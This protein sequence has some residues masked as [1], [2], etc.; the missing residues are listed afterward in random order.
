MKKLKVVLSSIV[1]VILAPILFVS[2][3][4]LINSYTNPDEVPSFFGWKPFIVLSGSMETEIYSGDVAVVKEVDL[5]EIN[6]NDIIA[7][8]EDD[9]V[10]THRVIDII[11]ENGTIKYKTKGDNN[12][13]ED[14]GYVL[15]EQVEGKYQFKVRR[16]GNFAMFAQTP[17]GM[18]VCLSIPVGLLLLI[19]MIDTRG[20]KKSQ[21]E[22][23]RKLQRKIELLEKQ[24][25]EL[26]KEGGKKWKDE[27]I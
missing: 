2:L 20:N 4:I 23:Q 17:I 16:L 22:A 6:K 3:V 14:G 1:L 27:L 18:I 10:I 19:Q 12:N 26:K 25:E 11:N 5:K 15:A 7:F 8:K 9:I 21:K 13:V 24:N